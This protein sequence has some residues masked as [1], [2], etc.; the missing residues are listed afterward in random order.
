MRSH[1]LYDVIIGDIPFN[2]RHIGRR[3]GVYVDNVNAYNSSIAAHYFGGDLRP[4]PGSG[5]HVNDR[6]TLLDHG[7][8]VIDLFELE[9]GTRSVP[10]LFGLLVVMVLFLVQLYHFL[11]WSVIY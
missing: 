9:R 1:L 6:L 3:Q 4:S 10:L 5:T 2:E 7:E 8:L 11:P